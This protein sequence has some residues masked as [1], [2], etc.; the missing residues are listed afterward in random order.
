MLQGKWTPHPSLSL[1]Q[2]IFF[3]P[4]F[5][6]LSS[7]FEEKNKSSPSPIRSSPQPTTSRPISKLS[8]SPSHLQGE[9][10]STSS[11]MELFPWVFPP[12]LNPCVSCKL[13]N[14]KPRLRTLK[15]AFG[16][17]DNVGEQSSRLR[18]KNINHSVVIMNLHIM[19]L[20]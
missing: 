10:S 11:S 5:H 18:L 6:F 14:S 3:L 2:T 16:W 13:G 20:T 8:S 1:L 15:I 19:M 7:F 12:K 9:C 17:L 4:S